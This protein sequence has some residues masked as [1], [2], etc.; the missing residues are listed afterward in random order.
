MYKLLAITALFFLLS[1][2]VSFNISAYTP[3]LGLVF[4][5]GQGRPTQIGV[6]FHTLVFF[7]LLIIL[8]KFITN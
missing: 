4:I 3:F 1:N 2:P 7:V 6:A 8:N 5:D